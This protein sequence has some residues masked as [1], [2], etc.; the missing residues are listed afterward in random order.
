MIL[1]VGHVVME[2][3]TPLVAEDSQQPGWKDQTHGCPGLT[4]KWLGDQWLEA[5]SHG[6]KETFHLSL[7]GGE[8][9]WL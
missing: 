5:Q 2:L 7:N 9:A 4:L 3:K 8:M 6:N 1:H